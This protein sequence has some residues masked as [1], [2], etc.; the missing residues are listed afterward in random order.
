MTTDAI[1]GLKPP[2]KVTELSSFFGF[3]IVFRRFL[4]NF[5]ILASPLMKK[6]RVDEPIKFGDLDD[7]KTTAF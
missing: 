7:V 5:V 4:P 1:E 3:Y 2:S 6:L